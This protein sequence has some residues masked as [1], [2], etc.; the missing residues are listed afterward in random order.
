MEPAAPDDRSPGYDSYG[1]N[2]EIEA[3]EM[4]SSG[5]QWRKSHQA[6]RKPIELATR[7]Y[8]RVAAALIAH[9][10]QRAIGMHSRGIMRR[11]RV[12]AR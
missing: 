1:S 5:R 7:S 10:V 2:I 11:D 12:F 3:G 9:L 8:P 6:S 4:T